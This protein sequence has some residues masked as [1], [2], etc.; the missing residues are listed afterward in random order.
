VIRTL[1][2]IQFDTETGSLSG[3]R[4]HV[5]LTESHRR[6][7]ERLTSAVGQTVSV[8]DLSAA[9][10]RAAAVP[11]THANVMRQHVTLLRWV[12]K[13]LGEFNDVWISNEPKRGYVVRVR[14]QA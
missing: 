11:T 5:D 3:P 12:L 2:K 6:L 1:G 4:G 13:A 10:Y 8:S 14:G 7:L 9:T